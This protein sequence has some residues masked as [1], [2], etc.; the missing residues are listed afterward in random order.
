MLKLLA[1]VVVSALVLPLAAD[2][3]A[4]EFACANACPLAKQANTHRAYGCEA[5]A[6]PS[7]AQADL[8]R[9][10]VANLARI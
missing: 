9:T 3:R 4:H 5:Q 1:M 6:V 8:A 2:E 10:V 7:V